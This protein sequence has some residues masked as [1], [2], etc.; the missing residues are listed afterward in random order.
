MKCFDNHLSPKERVDEIL[1]NFYLDHPYIE[2]D[3][4]KALEND[5]KAINGYFHEEE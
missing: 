4:K 3:D 2:R 5:W 1:D